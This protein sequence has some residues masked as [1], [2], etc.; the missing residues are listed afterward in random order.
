MSDVVVTS[1]EVYS[2]LDSDHAFVRIQR[3]GTSDKNED[4]SLVRDATGAIVNPRA[5]YRVYLY[6]N[7]QLGDFDSFNQAKKFALDTVAEAEAN[8][9]DF[10]RRAHTASEAARQAD[11]DALRAQL[12]EALAVNTRLR[13]TGN[14]ETTV[15]G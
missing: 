7:S 15:E 12:D 4:G 5:A 1:A 11:V 8:P 14:V 2:T 3:V 13:M 9:F 10:L 6:D